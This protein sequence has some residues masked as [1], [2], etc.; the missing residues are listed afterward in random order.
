MRPGHFGNG[1][2]GRGIIWRSSSYAQIRSTVVGHVGHHHADCL[3]GLVEH[4]SIEFVRSLAIHCASVRHPLS[5]SSSARALRPRPSPSTGDKA[6]KSQSGGVAFLFGQQAKVTFSRAPHPFHP[7]HQP[8]RRGGP[9]GGTC[10]QSHHKLAFLHCALSLTEE[11]SRPR[12]PE[13]HFVLVPSE[14]TLFVYRRSTRSSQ[15]RFFAL[16]RLPQADN[17]RSIERARTRMTLSVILSGGERGCRM[18]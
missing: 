3:V 15:V 2:E 12:Q 8:A 11:G 9:S 13:A 6:S 16:A 18:G 4:T 5:P 1:G 14:M 10:G 17:V 7:S